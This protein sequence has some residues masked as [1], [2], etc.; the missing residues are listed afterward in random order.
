MW[1]R[2]FSFVSRKEDEKNEKLL[3]ACKG[4]NA[5]DV[6]SLLKQGANAKYLY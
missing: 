5:D 6:L 4:N 1:G 3:V 2:L